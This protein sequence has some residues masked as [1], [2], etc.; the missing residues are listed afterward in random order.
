MDGGNWVGKGMRRE[1]RGSGSG[2]GKDRRI[3]R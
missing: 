2:V 1:W 3:A